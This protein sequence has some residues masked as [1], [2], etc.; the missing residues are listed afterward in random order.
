M[1]QSPD[2]VRKLDFVA[3]TEGRIVGNVVYLKSHIEADDG[4]RY[5][6]LSLGPLSVHPQYQRQGIGRMLIEH[7]GRLAAQMGFRAILLCG[8]SDYYS[9]V[10]FIRAEK[11]RHPD[12]R[13]HLFRCVAH[14]R[15]DRRIL[16]GATRTL[17]RKC[18]LRHKR[19]RS[20]RIRQTVSTQTHSRRHSL[21]KKTRRNPDTAKKSPIKPDTDTT[22]ALLPLSSGAIRFQNK[23]IYRVASCR[24]GPAFR[25]CDRG[26]ARRVPSDAPN[27]PSKGCAYETPLTPRD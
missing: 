2:F 20:R 13:E 19:R 12:G 9:R 26:T 25:A 1:R 3:V 16:G 21:A 6:V 24:S 27:R 18:D 23:V 5:E 15:I 14:P 11:I 7:T 8:D 4:N 10:G 17:Y 22:I